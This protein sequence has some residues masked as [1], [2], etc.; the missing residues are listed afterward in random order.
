MLPQV[1]KNWIM[2]NPEK[3]RSPAYFNHAIKSYEKILK[4]LC[5]PITFTLA[6]PA[7]ITREIVNICEDLLKVVETVSKPEKDLSTVIIKK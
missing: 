7:T 4:Y 6:N 5:F 3:K 2:A 1:L